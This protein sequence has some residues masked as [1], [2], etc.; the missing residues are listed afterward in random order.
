MQKEPRGFTLVEV[1]VVVIILALIAATIV[2]KLIGRTYTAK[3]Q[4]TQTN[5]ASIEGCI[6]I[7]YQDTGR[8]P[9]AQEGLTALIEKPNNCPN[10]HGPYLED[11]PVD[12]WHRSFIYQIPGQKRAFDIFSTGSDGKLGGEG[13][14]V[15][16]YRQSLKPITEKP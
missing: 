8:Y 10:W 2:P 9:T 4:L 1:L 13:E 3:V 14:A 16:I 6:R 5:I 7:F 12:A 11:I 15:D